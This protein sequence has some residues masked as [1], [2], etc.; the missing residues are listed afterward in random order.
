MKKYL[1]LFL[2]F[3]I[4]TYSLLGTSLSAAAP[5]PPAPPQASQTPQTPP[6][7]P[8]LP[9]APEAPDAPVYPTPTP[10]PGVTPVPTDT[11]KTSNE[12]KCNSI[13]ANY[14]SCAGG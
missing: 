9:Q 14:C 12:G 1:S 11:E 2:I 6:P 7:P 5:L 10:I 13:G 3:I 4:T 8:P